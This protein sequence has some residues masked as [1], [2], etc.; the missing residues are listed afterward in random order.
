MRGHIALLAATGCLSFAATVTADVTLSAA[1]AVDNRFIASISTSPTSA[2]IPFLTG[3][4]WQQTY[5]GN[6]V[7]P[8]AGTY[9]L[10]VEATDEGR[11]EM[12]IG[13][14]GLSGDAGAAFSNGT[15][16]LLSNST[17]WSV[18]NTGFGDNTVAPLDLGLNSGASPW[19][20]RPGIDGA[21]HFLWAPQY[22]PTVYFTS[23]IRIVPA[24]TGAAVLSLGLLVGARRR[25]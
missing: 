25:R 4:N 9:Y 16:S 22:T 8:G 6:F 17:D 2:G 5:T 12:F 18:S 13:Q 11:P 21:A 10:Q 23:V 19:G 14:F 15:L 1:I 3:N 7:F 20:T 24:P